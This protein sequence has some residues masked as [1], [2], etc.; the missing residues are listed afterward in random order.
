VRTE[1]WEEDQKFQKEGLADILLSSKDQNVSKAQIEQKQKDFIEGLQ[2]REFVYKRDNKVLENT[3]K[4]YYDGDLTEDMDN[5][6]AGKDFPN[7]LN[8]EGTPL[9][10]DWKPSDEAKPL[11]TPY[12]KKSLDERL[13]TDLESEYNK[14]VVKPLVGAL[15]ASKD[16]F[17]KEFDGQAYVEK[18]VNQNGGWDYSVNNKA[19]ESDA[20]RYGASFVGNT[21]LGVKHKREKDAMEKIA[22]LQLRN[23]GFT[24]EQIAQELPNI[25]FNT[26]KQNYIEMAQR[27]VDS[28]LKNQKEDPLRRE[29]KGLN[30]NIGGGISKGTVSLDPIKKP[31]PTFI[32][33]KYNPKIK[34]AEE[35]IAEL[36]AVAK[37]NKFQLDEIKAQKGLIESLKKGEGLEQGKHFKFSNKKSG[38]DAFISIN[39]N[40]QRKLFRLED[41]TPTKDGFE[42]SGVERI[43][44]DEG[45]N[46]DTPV[47]Y[48]LTLDIYTDIINEN[49][50][51]IDV[52][53]EAGIKPNAETTTK[54]APKK[55][56]AKAEPKKEVLDKAAELINKYRKK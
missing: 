43:K 20:N 18:T 47:F 32:E 38:D 39:P 56:A 6:F 48:P 29:S 21:N 41:I 11:N 31:S 26:A 28:R 24:D 2:K 12:F 27:D 53:N 50:D 5:L 51:A 22:V 9:N 8:Q 3:S 46:I 16:V 52:F 54:V 13:K 17:S 55:E 35:R 14:R 33:A 15:D 25:M 45:K 42:I 36:E 44:D 7:A 10:T 49:P 30:I 4:A 23:N 34:K 37:P 40:N 19:I 1:D